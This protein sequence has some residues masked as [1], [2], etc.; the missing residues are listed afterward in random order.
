METE[1]RRVR[2]TLTD[3][4]TQNFIEVDRVIL[5]G[6][7]L[8]LYNYHQQIEQHLNLDYI[9]TVF[10]APMPEKKAEKLIPIAATSAEEKEPEL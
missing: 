8:S 6:G 2:I 4:T 9:L 3:G 1:R 5:E 10:V 7:F